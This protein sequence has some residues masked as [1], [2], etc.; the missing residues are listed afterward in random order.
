M[1]AFTNFTLRPATLDDATLF[2]S[3]IDLTM[4][5]FILATWGRRCEHQLCGK[6]SIK[7]RILARSDGYTRLIIRCLEPLNYVAARMLVS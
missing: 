4:R 6:H 1:R 2:Y 3:V 5:E 7:I